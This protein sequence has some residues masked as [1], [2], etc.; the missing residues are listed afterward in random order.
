MSTDASI[1]EQVGQRV[2]RVR[3]AAGLSQV[4]LAKA[5]GVS[6]SSIVSCETGRSCLRVPQLVYIAAACG[7]PVSALLEGVR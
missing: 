5:A 3:K 6:G 1:A 7:V 2:A 4:A